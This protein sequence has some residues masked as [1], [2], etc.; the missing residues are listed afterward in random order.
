VNWLGRELDLRTN[1]LK[2]ID[3]KFAALIVQFLVSVSFNLMGSFLP[4]FIKTDLN[5]PLIEAT[6]WT[7]VAQLVASSLFAVTAPFWGSMCDRIGI[8]KITIIVL[9]ANAVVYTGMGMSTDVV[10]ILLFR[11]LQ[12]SFGGVSTAMFS[13]VAAIYVGAELKQAISYQIATMTLG[14]LVGPGLG[15]LLASLIGYRLTLT[16]S[17]L[18]FVGII[19]IMF[20]INVPPPSRKT[21]E[22]T[23]FTTSDFKAIIPDFVSLI[24]VYACIQFIIPAIPWFLGSFGIPSEQLLLYTTLTTTLNGVAFAVATPLLPRI[25]SDRKLPLVSL[26]A[27]GAIFMTAFVTNPIHFIGVR[28]AAGAIQAGI[29]PFLLG[30]RGA[31]R[32]GTAMGFLNSAR[33]MGIA[34]GP[35]TATSIL[36]GGEPFRVLGMFATMAVFSLIASLVIYFTHKRTS[37]LSN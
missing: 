12:G 32:K 35:I 18:L 31:Q 4:L 25:L 17:S 2:G 28:V 30:G 24:L 3:I 34:I 5:Y 23:R 7:S 22:K 15:G 14:S 10:H 21:S 19:P 33:F 36:G 9:V 27:S 26:A 20:L 13:L 6:Y 1:V 29:P 11:G 8:K 37:Y 16:A